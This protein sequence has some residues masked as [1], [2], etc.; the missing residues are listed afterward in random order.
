[1]SSFQ[2]ICVAHYSC[3]FCLISFDC[4]LTSTCNI[5]CPQATYVSFSCPCQLTSIHA[6]R[7]RNSHDFNFNS[8][9]LNSEC[10]AILYPKWMHGFNDG[11]VPVDGSLLLRAEMF[12]MDLYYIFRPRIQFLLLQAT[13]REAWQ[14]GTEQPIGIQLSAFNA[15]SWVLLVGIRC[16]DA[17]I[18]CWELRP[19]PPLFFTEC[20]RGQTPWTR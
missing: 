11:K 9:H 19:A 20:Q 4:T 17:L 3:H 10:C 2:C 7:F 6:N 8:C 18:G 13:R 16:R 14:R 5:S 12:L 15:V 1:M